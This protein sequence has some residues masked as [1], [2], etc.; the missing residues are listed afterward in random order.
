M[1]I[2]KLHIFS[3]NTDAT[4]SLRG[5]H[6]QVLKTLETLIKNSLLDVNDEIYCDFEED[7]FQKNE[8]TGTTK[9]RQIKLYSRNFSFS[10]E[11]IQKCL[12]HFFM[13]HVKT[14]YAL[15]EKEFIF[16][17]NSSVANVRGDNDAE[18]LKN[19]NKHQGDL[20]EELAKQCADKAKEIIT[21]YI[22][23]QA[24][25]ID[26]DDKNSLVK[27]AIDVFKNLQ[28]SD[29]I[30]FIKKI[31]W[32][33][34][35]TKPDIEFAQLKQSIE[36]DILKLPFQI[37]K[38]NLPSIFGELH[39]LA[40]N[41]ATNTK[42]EDK[43]LT[44][45]ELND[46]LLRSSNDQDKWYWVVYERWENTEKINDFVI[47]QFYE[48][49]DA[50]RHC[51][52]TRYLTKHKEDWLKLLKLY[53]DNPK[54]DDNFKRVAIY[55]YLWLLLRP[56][57]YREIPEGNLKGEEEYFRLYF[58]DFDVFKTGKELEDAQSLM[59]IAVAA[60]F[61]DKTNL[62]G[63]EVQ[64][65]FDSM[66]NT[67]NAKI[68]VESN[69][70][71]KCHLLENLATHLLFLNSNR[72]KQDKNINEVLNPLK[73]I[74][75]LLDKADYY[76]VSQLSTRLD[77]YIELLIEADAESNIELIDGINDYSE[78]LNPIVET[79]GGSFMGA[80]AELGR[81]IKY[82]NSNVP[83][84]SLRALQCFHKAKDKFNIQESFEGYVLSLI[85]IAQLY[86]SIGMNLAA[87]YYALAA[88]WASMH[89]GD[90]KL[91]KRIVDA[92]GIA[93]YADFKQGAWLNAIVSSMDYIDARHELKATPLDPNVDEMP[94][95]VLA[96]LAMVFHLTP[97]M[98][99]E[100]TDMVSRNMDGLQDLSDEFLKPAIA[101]LEETN[102]TYDSWIPV[103]E[104]ILTDKPLN[105][106][107]HTRLVR[108][109]ALGIEWKI[110]FANNY[111]M[112]SL[113][114][115]FCGIVQIT[116]AEI[117]LSNY[118]FHL[119]R[120]SVSIELEI[121]NEFKGPELQPSNDEIIWKAWVKHTDTQGEESLL[122]ITSCT[123]SIGRILS[124]LSLLPFDDFDKL[125]DTLF[126]ESDLAKKTLIGG[127]YQRMYRTVYS[128]TNF[129]LMQRD[130][131]TPVALT[132]MNLPQTNKVM[133]WKHSLSNLYDQVE[134]K[135][136]IEQRLKNSHK[137]SYLTIAKLKQNPDFPVFIK[138]LRSQ[139]WQDWHIFL[140]I[141]NFILTHK[142]E[143]RLRG[144]T[145]PT[146]EDFDRLFFEIKKLDESDFEAEFPLEA[147]T[148]LEF[149]FNLKNTIILILKSFGLANPS[150]FPNFLAIREFLD[151]RFNMIEDGSGENNPFKDL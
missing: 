113:A 142:T 103:L 78:K 121:D 150:R 14:D 18:L 92:L 46:V 116:L 49:I 89:N 118:D 50:T 35:N 54:I 101:K 19:W 84:L 110:S 97:K 62:D 65:W 60:G 80:K 102:S 98:S 30:E 34:N 28:D 82:L 140:A 47:G 48:V 123:K 63:R 21:Q 55:E 83:K 73:D 137:N 5:Y 10:N 81:G 6:Y 131:F 39:T 141:N 16:E 127:L 8:I 85:N 87:K 149:E 88:V 136:R 79:R 4:A 32:V 66:F 2:S 76:N 147:F 117:A 24:K 70:N 111:E 33:F 77:E 23:K 53:I 43:K 74:L 106:V 148:S 22:E 68:K 126:S 12:A 90:R 91:L 20:S 45:N 9:F 139:G 119:I 71:E 134:A 57:N 44:L 132:D 26:E 135:K 107:G 17:A 7:I 38:E 128:K 93:F 56:I 25:A 31:K 122:N 69:P 86:S 143:F 120:G 41:K 11:E 129:D 37:N 145:N 3:K 40:W 144:I 99:P 115:D 52:V 67:L 96:D 105:D 114:E 58:K 64:G 130:N 133:K 146:Q 27:E 59:N 104:R 125:L 124:N 108:F 138:K 61:M 1:N 72:N 29:W 51:R 151:V 112:A 36:D 100:L 95:K 94:F 109:N 75:K 13:L 15:L 42:I